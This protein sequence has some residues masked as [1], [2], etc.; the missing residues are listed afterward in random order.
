VIREAGEF[1]CLQIW[2]RGDEPGSKILETHRI[3][4]IIE[5]K[6]KV[7]DGRAEE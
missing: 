4:K 7:L 2:D 5:S 1:E 6:T 3:L